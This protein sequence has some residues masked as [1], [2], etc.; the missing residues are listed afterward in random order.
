MGKKI[1]AIHIYN[2][3]IIQHVKK[4]KSSTN[5]NKRKNTIYIKNMNKIFGK[6]YLTKEYI[7]MFNKYLKRWLTSFVNM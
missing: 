4:K 2:K 3:E 7:E 1:L 5:H 6:R